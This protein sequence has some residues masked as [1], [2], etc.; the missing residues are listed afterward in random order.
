MVAHGKEREAIAWVALTVVLWSVIAIAQ[1]LPRRLAGISRLVL[2]RGLVVGVSI[3]FLVMSV[4]DPLLQLGV[5]GLP[6]SSGL[7]IEVLFFVPAGLLLL[8]VARRLRLS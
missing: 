8:F 3:F 1:A 5:Q 4:L 7:I 2:L 6:L